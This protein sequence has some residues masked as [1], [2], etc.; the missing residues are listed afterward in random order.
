M[1][2]EIM[3]PEAQRKAI[4]KVC[5]WRVERR[6]TISELEC[7]FV[8][9]DPRGFDVSY[10]FS[11][12]TF[13]RGSIPNYPESLSA[14]HEAEKVLTDEQWAFWKLELSTL[15]GANVE[16][17]HKRIRLMFHATA[18]QRAEA[19]LRTLNLWTE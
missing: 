13:L 11:E 1:E 5:G 4:M 12:D 2:T 3:T 19:F 18:S 10:A 15:V 6:A 14:M 16:S 8:L 7:P 9:F 17:G